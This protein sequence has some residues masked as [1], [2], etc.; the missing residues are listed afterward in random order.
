MTDSLSVCREEQEAEQR[1]AAAEREKTSAE[2][3][4]HE[5]AVETALG[6]LIQ[7]MGPARR[8]GLLRKLVVELLTQGAR[9]LDV[10]GLN[11][12]ASPEFGLLANIADIARTRMKQQGGI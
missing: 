10:E 5:A 3:V 12:L 4:E 1:A 11:T 7:Q 8:E 6:M 9:C 2:Q